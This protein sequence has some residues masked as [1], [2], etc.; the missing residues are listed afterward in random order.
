MN[1][2]ETRTML[3][4]PAIIAAGWEPLNIRE[5]YPVQ[6]GTKIGN[7]KRKPPKKADYVLQYKGI[8]LA[9]I[10]AKSDELPYNDGVTQA[11]KYAKKLGI[12]HTYST[13]GLEIYHI[14]STVIISVWYFSSDKVFPDFIN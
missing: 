4:Y 6:D 12:R 7:G 1:E 2:A 14:N 3:I 5:E 11:K 9:V 10:E 8:N 13:N